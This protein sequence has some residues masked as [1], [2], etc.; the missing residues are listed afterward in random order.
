LEELRLEVAIE[1]GG[2]LERQDPIANQYKIICNSI[3]ALLKE[4][5]LIKMLEDAK[6]M[7]NEDCVTRKNFYKKISIAKEILISALLKKRKA[8]INM[9]D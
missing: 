3:Y 1:H 6:M 8:H 4:E 2:E 5:N 9:K 7:K